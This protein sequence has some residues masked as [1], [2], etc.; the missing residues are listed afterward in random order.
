VDV[1]VPVSGS[2]KGRFS[3][4]I[5]TFKQI[6]GYW[7][8]KGKVKVSDKMIC[9]ILKRNFLSVCVSVCMDVY[10]VYAV[11]EEARRWHWIPWDW[12]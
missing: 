4:S 8:S 10:H 1:A 6:C 7:C 12:S 9:R 3:F 2:D 5:D 11:L